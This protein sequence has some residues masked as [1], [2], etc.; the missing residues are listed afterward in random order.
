M[1][2]SEGTRL[3]GFVFQPYPLGGRGAK[4]AGRWVS[5]CPKGRLVS[6]VKA[7]LLSP[8]EPGRVSTYV[9]SIERLSAKI[10]HGHAAT[11]HWGQWP[12]S[13]GPRARTWRRLS[14]ARHGPVIHSAQGLG[15]G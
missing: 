15:S 6:S 5:G 12:E 10:G 14:S 9:L 7:S 2:K 3:T 13:V 11:C 4:C 8:K 1:Q